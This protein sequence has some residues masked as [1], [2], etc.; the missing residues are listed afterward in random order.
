MVVAQGEEDGLFGPFVDEVQGGER[1]SHG[2]PVDGIA[3][4]QVPVG[5]EPIRISAKLVDFPL[6]LVRLVSLDP[7]AGEGRTDIV[8]QGVLKVH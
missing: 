8:F 3:G 6:G 1:V 4:V 7:N 2:G 5:V